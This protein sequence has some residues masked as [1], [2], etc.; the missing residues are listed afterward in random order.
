MPNK[1]AQSVRPCSPGGGP[2]PKSGSARSGLKI[3]GRSWIGLSINFRCTTVG[4]KG[5]M[6]KNVV[7]AA[8]CVFVAAP[9][10]A[11]PDLQVDPGTYQSGNGGPFKVTIFDTITNA[12]GTESISPGIIQTFCIERNEYLAWGG[13]Y[14]AQLNTAAVNGGVGGPSP[15]PLGAKTA[16]LYTQYLD[17]LF[18]T[19]M[20]IDSAT[21][22]GQLQ[23]AIWHFEQEVSNPAN[24]YV[25]YADL[26]CNWT[27]TGDIRVL[28]LWQNSDFTG[29][30]QDVLARVSNPVPA[31]GAL[32][33][34]SLGMGVVGWFRR[35]GLFT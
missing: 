33:L 2:L 31:P 5:M 24:P 25:Q 17:D 9:A 20:K 18:P 6:M 28:N 7:I 21:D 4:G 30:Q 11:V 3:T 13:Q 23:N 16:W 19:A 14:Y 1:A 10:F 12:G 29:P 27:T 26:N 8:V 35:K 32:L 34:G 22:A 15:D